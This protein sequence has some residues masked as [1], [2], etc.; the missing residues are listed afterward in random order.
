MQP[1]NHA[2]RKQHE[3]VGVAN[4]H[5]YTAQHSG[6]AD[7][8][9][10]LDQAATQVPVFAIEF[11]DAATQV[12]VWRQPKYLNAVGKPVDR[13]IC[14]HGILRRNR[15]Q[16]RAEHGPTQIDSTIS[17]A[18]CA[19]APESRTIFLQAASPNECCRTVFWED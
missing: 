7:D 6:C 17:Q 8:R 16:F 1:E 13:L 10:E 19:R 18:C 15:H 2:A 11:R 4:M 14:D 9:I 5:M 12:V 3:M